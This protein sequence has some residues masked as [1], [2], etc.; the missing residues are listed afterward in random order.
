MK[1]FI[2]QWLLWSISRTDIRRRKNLHFTERKA[3]G[4]LLLIVHFF[5]W[6]LTFSSKPRSQKCFFIST[7]QTEISVY[8]YYPQSV[9]LVPAVPPPSSSPPTNTHW[10]V[11][12]M[13]LLT[14]QFYS[15]SCYSFPIQTKYLAQ[16]LFQH[17]ISM[18]SRVEH[19]HKHT[20]SNTILCNQNCFFHNPDLLCEICFICCVVDRASYFSGDKKNQIDVTFYSWRLVG[21]SYP[22]CFICLNHCI[23]YKVF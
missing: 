12:T 8:F 23:R 3:T 21:F 4:I 6:S 1:N 10:P 17:N 2:P 9:S 14:V 22:H 19:K 16:P 11:Q 7:F 18:F 13:Q 20:T 15:S 5:V